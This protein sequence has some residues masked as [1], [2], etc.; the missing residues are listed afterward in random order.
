MFGS[1][2]PSLWSSSNHSL[3]GLR[4]PTLLCNHVPSRCDVANQEVCSRLSGDCRVT[5]LWAAR[6][7]LPPVEIDFIWRIHG[8]SGS[9][10]ARRKKIREAVRQGPAAIE[11]SP[12][13]CKS[14]GRFNEARTNDRKEARPVCRRESEDCEGGE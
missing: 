6:L 8:H 9:N 1:F 5:Y 2:L 10:Q 13:R 12:S 3:L 7:V 14:F 11:W 4:E